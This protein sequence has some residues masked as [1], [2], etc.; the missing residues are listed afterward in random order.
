MRI[1]LNLDKYEWHF[2]QIMSNFQLKKILVLKLYDT[3]HLI[4]LKNIF[5][6]LCFNFNFW[7]GVLKWSFKHYLVQLMKPNFR[8]YFSFFSSVCM[9]TVKSQINHFEIYWPILHN[10]TVYM[11][12]TVFK[13]FNKIIL[14][15]SYI[16]WFISVWN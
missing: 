12:I 5:T 7:S 2:N 14:T 15:L 10:P 9:I 13:P 16:A 11:L 6:V 4:T 1:P 3:R 8:Y